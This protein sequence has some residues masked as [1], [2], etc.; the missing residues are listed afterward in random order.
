MVECIHRILSTVWA[1]MTEAARGE[2]P[3]ARDQL[4]FRVSGLFAVRAMVPQVENPN[5]RAAWFTN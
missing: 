1:R 3:M 2:S 4:L 5:A